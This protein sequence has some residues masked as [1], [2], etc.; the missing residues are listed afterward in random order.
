M[1]QSDDFD[2]M[3]N[4]TPRAKHVLV[5]AQKEAEKFNHDYVGTEH[6]LLGLIVLGEGLR[7]LYLS[8]WG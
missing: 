5:L 1:A 4:F 3:K 8:P 7:F 6:L 2:A